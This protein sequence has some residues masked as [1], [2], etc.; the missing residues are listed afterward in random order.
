MNIFDQCNEAYATSNAFLK[1][2]ATSNA[3]LQGL[4]FDFAMNAWMFKNTISSTYFA[5][6]Q[7]ISS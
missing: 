1:P 7:H 2:Y 6:V 3:L 5:L 4:E